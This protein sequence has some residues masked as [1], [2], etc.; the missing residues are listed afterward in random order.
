MALTGTQRA[1]LT[2]RLGVARLGAI[3]LGFAPKAT[4]GETP[5]SQGGFYSWRRVYPPTTAWT[6]VK[7]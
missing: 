7:R 4:Q 5:G 1:I 2:A 3:R 6:A